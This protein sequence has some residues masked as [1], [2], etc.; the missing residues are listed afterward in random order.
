MCILVPS[1]IWFLIYLEFSG[2]TSF[3]CFC[4][5]LAP[6]TDKGILNLCLFPSNYQVRIAVLKVL[7]AR[8]RASNP[9]ARVQVIGYQSRPTL[10]LTPPTD[11]S[12][13]RVKVFNYIE[14]VKTLPTNFT[15]SEISEIMSKVNPRLYKSLRETFIVISDDLPKVNKQRGLGDQ[16]GDSGSGAS[17]EPERAGKRQSSSSSSEQSR[18]AKSAK[19]R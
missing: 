17:R 3:A 4:P 5:K 12:D 11:A 8:Y 19:S 13:R 18:T 16:Q 7:G 6:V 2:L 9:G 1:Q 14:A 10:R 15:E